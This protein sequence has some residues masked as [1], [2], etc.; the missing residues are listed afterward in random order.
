MLLSWCPQNALH[1]LAAGP[2]CKGVMVGTEWAISHSGWVNRLRR[3]YPQLV[4]SPQNAVHKVATG[5]GCKGSWLALG[6][7][8]H[9]LD[10]LTGLE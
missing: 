4:G 8:I 9:A 7:P 2:G 10:A 6:G 1:I 5:L 3:Y